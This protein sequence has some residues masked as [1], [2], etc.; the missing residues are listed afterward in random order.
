MK[1]S[2]LSADILEGKLTVVRDADTPVMNIDRRPDR[3]LMCSS[4]LPDRYKAD[5]ERK[6]AYVRHMRKTG[7]TKGQRD[8]ISDAIISCSILLK[9]DH[10]PQAPAVMKWMRDYEMSGENLASLISKNVKRRTSKRLRRDIRLVVEQ[11]LTKHYFVKNGCSMRTAHERVIEALD[12]ASP[13]SK[14]PADHDVSLSTV[15]RII[16][17]TSPFDRDRIRLGAARTRAKWRYSKPGQASTRPL[18]RVEIDHTLMDA[19]V[20]DDR[21]ILPL[22]R[23]VI[24]LIVCTYSGYILGFFISFEGETIGRMVQCIKIAIQPKD[25]ITAG[26]SLSNAWHS[27]GGWE[28]LCLDNS[29]AGHTSPFQHIA[30][31]LG[32]DLEYCP[33][34]MPW[35]KPSVERC[36]GELTRQ[37][38]ANGRP[39]KPGSGPDP[40]NPNEDACITFSDLC[41]GILKWIVDVHPFEINERKL[42]RPID[43]FLEGLDSCPPPTLLDNTTCLD[44]MAGVGTTATVDHG[45]MVRQYLR[46][47]NDELVSLRREIGVNFKANVKYDPYNLGHVYLQHPRT[48][49][50]ITVGARDE[51]YASGLTLTQHKLIRRAAGNKLTLRNAETVLRK[52]RLELQDHWANAIR[53]GKRLKKSSRDLGLLQGL[54]SVSWPHHPGNQALMRVVTDD[55]PAVAE[56]AIPSFEVFTGVQP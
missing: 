46:Y 49:S 22:G 55:D 19:T 2:K 50:W 14:T 25:K 42:A 30:M 47:T 35:F 5:L 52:A 48:G 21:F 44:V 33:V 24:T 17:E 7:L 32:M 26:H 38:P 28:T 29:L 13:A 34:R 11:I 45:G 15:R 16:L 43:L 23:P 53:G 39:R 41:Y 3:S 36:L 54:S 31:D 8:R 51:E 10:P 1:I 37:L 20:I 6:Y 4:T 18:E 9:D 27:M 40:F 12:Q 56:A